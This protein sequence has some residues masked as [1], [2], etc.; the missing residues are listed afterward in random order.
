MAVRQRYV[1]R[2][3]VLQPDVN[4]HGLRTAGLVEL[5]GP[6]IFPP[7]LLR[8][9][10]VCVTKLEHRPSEGTTRQEACST[11]A[12]C[13]CRHLLQVQDKPVTTR[14]FSFTECV[15]NLLR[16]VL[17]DLLPSKWMSL[18]RRNPQEDNKKRMQRVDTFFSASESGPLLR[19]ACL[20]LR[21]T[22]H[23][24]S[25]CSQKPKPGNTPLLV[26]LGNF[27]IQRKAAQDVAFLLPRLANDPGID[28]PSTILGLLTTATHLL[29]RFSVFSRCPSRIW[30]L[31]KCL[32]LQRN[33]DFSSLVE[34]LLKTKLPV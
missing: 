1:F 22:L 17:L 14:F 21:L 31:S 33:I 24:V 10:N 4:D 13:L 29:I 5:Y 11:V 30:T 6:F 27:E 15:N 12:D 19:R 3:L 16:M 26:R 9:L 32:G 34:P 20:C 2:N 28:I 8:C 23:A 25:I 7:D 18:E